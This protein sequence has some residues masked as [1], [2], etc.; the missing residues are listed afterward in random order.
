MRQHG[1]R[2]VSAI[3]MM[4]IVGGIASH[5]FAVNKKAEAAKASYRAYIRQVSSEEY[6]IV[7]ID[8]NGIPELVIHTPSQNTVFTYQY[9]K[10]KR[11]KLKSVNCGKGYAMPLKYNVKKHQVEIPRGDTGGYTIRFYRVKGTGISQVK[12]F[13]WRNPNHYKNYGYFVDGK[14]VSEKVYTKK[15]NSATKGFRAVN[16]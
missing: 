4:V 6:K 9:S 13:E 7:D 8:K 10:K 2:I 15:Y 3:L 5:A 16:G 1:R 12:K 11:I 14:K